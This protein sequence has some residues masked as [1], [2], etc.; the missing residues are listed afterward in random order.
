MASVLRHDA[1]ETLERSSTFYASRR[2]MRGSMS[3]RRR[4]KLETCERYIQYL[5]ERGD[6]DVDRQGFVS[7]VQQHF[8]SLPTR[9]AL[10]V[11][12]SGTNILRH[13]DLLE[14]AR[15]YPASVAFMVREIE[16]LYPRHNQMVQLEAPVFAADSTTT[17]TVRD[18]LH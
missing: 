6:V 15:K 14:Q 16:L 13:M 7:S 12:T 8:E 9:Y 11:D 10:D 3:H 2:G 18:S 17:V 5:R 4:T 1:D